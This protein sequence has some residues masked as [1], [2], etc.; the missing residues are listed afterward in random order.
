[1]EG[2]NQK[3][4]SKNA[5][6]KL[7]KKQKREREKAEKMKKLAEQG[8]LNEGTDAHQYYLNRCDAI[9]QLK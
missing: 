4:M 8:K 7:L 1:M 3:P 6:K 5:R 2:D 9:K